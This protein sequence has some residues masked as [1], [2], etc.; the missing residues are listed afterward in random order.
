MSWLTYMASADQAVRKGNF[1]VAEGHL[2]DALQAAEQYGSMSRE[3]MQTGDKLA[4]VLLQQ[5]KF[6]DAEDLLLRLAELKTQAVGA[7][8]PETGQTMLQLGGLYYAQGKY[9]QA[10]PFALGALRVM[11][12]AHGP[13]HAETAKVATNLAYIY[14]AQEKY[15]QAEQY[16][17]RA[18]STK[19]TLPT[20]EQG[21]LP[22]LVSLLAGI[23]EETGRQQEALSLMQSI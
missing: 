13:D 6:A 7:S 15:A 14:H 12:G 18:I 5:S 8:A 20:E 17:Q 16:Y 3:I 22:S 10:E 23:L 11:E 9:S 19:K 1:E 21:D 2:W 4:D